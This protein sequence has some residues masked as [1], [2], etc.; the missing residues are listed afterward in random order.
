MI[1][2][3]DCPLYKLSGR[4][5]QSVG[6]DEQSSADFTSSTIQTNSNPASKWLPLKGSLACGMVL[7]PVRKF[8]KRGCHCLLFSLVSKR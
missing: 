7:R 6:R 3:N 8:I 1:W 2:V 4:G 5:R